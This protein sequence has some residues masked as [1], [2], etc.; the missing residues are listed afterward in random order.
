MT[1]KYCNNINSS[2]LYTETHSL[3]LLDEFD[4]GYGTRVNIETSLGV[5]KI[6]AS[7]KDDSNRYHHA[8]FK[9]N[10]C[11]MCGRKLGD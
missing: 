3:N 9:I 7:F 6:L 4:A 1:C 10:Y 5:S 8:S 11:P 2:S